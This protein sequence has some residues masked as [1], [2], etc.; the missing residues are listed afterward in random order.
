MNWTE[1]FPR[2]TQPDMDEIGRALQNPLWEELNAHLQETYGV[3]PTITYSVC[4]GAPGWNVKYRKGGR[5]LCV[6]YPDLDCFTCMV[7][8]GPREQRE[9]ELLLTACT[10]YTQGLYASSGG[11]NGTRWM[12]LAVTS[13][14]VLE[15]AKALISTR[16]KKGT[17]R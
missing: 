10:A 7:C 9:A 12:M 3:A 2:T 5:A 1:L 14:D 6:L 8:I 11:V 4:S 15:D 16:I 17:G 13:Q